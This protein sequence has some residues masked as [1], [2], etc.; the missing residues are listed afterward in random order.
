VD[1]EGL[2]PEAIEATTHRRPI[3]AQADP[4]GGAFL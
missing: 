2:A 1:A 4:H 3:G